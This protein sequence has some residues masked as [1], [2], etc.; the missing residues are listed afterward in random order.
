MSDNMF[1]LNHTYQMNL[2]G[3]GIVVATVIDI[4]YLAG[5]P[6]LMFQPANGGKTIIVQDLTKIGSW[7]EVPTAA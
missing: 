4:D 2:E 3:F 1:Q 7:Q 6:V 5:K